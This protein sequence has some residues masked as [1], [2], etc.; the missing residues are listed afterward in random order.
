MSLREQLSKIEERIER[1]CASVGRAKEEV[2]LVAVT[3]TVPLDTIRAA[4]ELG[5]RDFGESRV[6]EA[7]P[8]IAELPHDIRWHFI[9]ALQSNK[10]KLV[11][12]KFDLIHSIDRAAQLAEIAKQDRI[13]DVL[14]EVNLADEPQKAGVQVQGLDETI[15]DCANCKRVRLRGLMMIGPMLEPEEMRPFYRSLKELLRKVPGGDILSMGMSADY[16]VAIQ[17]GST[18]VRIGTALF[19]DRGSHP[20]IG[21]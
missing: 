8:K 18:H 21:G 1:A 16:E 5:L 17:E 15:S 6:Q 19:G 3:K 13:V 11:A 2:T 14:I 4:Y 12:A 20:R 7:L 10:A 9:G